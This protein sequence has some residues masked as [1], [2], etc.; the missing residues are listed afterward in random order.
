MCVSP[1]YSSSLIA[2]RY[3]L[4][5]TQLSRLHSTVVKEIMLNLYHPSIH[6]YIQKMF[7]QIKDYLSEHIIKYISDVHTY[8]SSFFVSSDSRLFVSY[9]L[10]LFVGNVT[11]EPWVSKPPAHCDSKIHCTV[12]RNGKDERTRVG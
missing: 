11:P 2:L 12:L 3:L 5:P 8:P 10:I 4:Y 7:L 9:I 6:L 1:L